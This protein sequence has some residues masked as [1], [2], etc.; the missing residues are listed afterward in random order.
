MAEF[1]GLP[2]AILIAGGVYLLTL[3]GSIT[4]QII[5][6]IL[7]LGGSALHIVYLCLTQK[8]QEAYLKTKTNNTQN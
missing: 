8:N 5:G 7:I 3:K 1:G 6:G 2:P 4:L